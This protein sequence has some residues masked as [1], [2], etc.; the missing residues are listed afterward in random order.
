MSV[1][2]SS[3]KGPA[4]GNTT[5]G[6]TIGE[7]FR[8]DALI[9][10]GAMGVV[11]RAHHIGLHKD[12]ALKLLRRELSANAEMV[13]RF[14]REAAAASRLDHV[15]CVR[16]LDFG[17]TDDGRSYLVM[18][19]LDGQELAA[20]VGAP[21][22]HDRA[23]GILE[24]VLR[25]LGHAHAHGLVHRDVKPENIFL[26]EGSSGPVVKLLDFGLVKIQDAQGEGAA[27]LTRA[28]AIFGT[29]SYM[30]PEQCVGKN[31]DL[32]TDIYSA[33]VVM[34]EML[35]GDRPFVGDGPAEVLRGHVTD[36]PPPI[37]HA[38]PQ[39]LREL[40]VRMMQKKAEDRF[41]TAN[42]ALAAL[43]AAKRQLGS[44]P[45]GAPPRRGVAL[46]PPVPGLS[47][48]KPPGVSPPLS[49]PGSTVRAA[50]PVVP[51]SPGRAMPQPPPAEA[52]GPSASG[53]LPQI[54][55]PV[56]ATPDAPRAP[57]VATPAPP[58]PAAAPPSPAAS[59]PSPA[60]GGP[61]SAASSPSARAIVDDAVARVRA[62]LN[63]RPWLKPA[64]IGGVAL[65]A[66]LVVA[67]WPGDDERGA[68]ASDANAAD[69]EV[70]ADAR[71]DAKPDDDEAA[72]G[73]KA[74]DEIAID[75]ADG[76]AAGDEPGR[77][78]RALR[79][80]L[81]SIDALLETKNYDSARIMLGPLLEVYEDEPGLHWRMATVLVRL[82]PKTNG[83][84]ALQSYR[85][86][87]ALDAALLDDPK[88]A[89]ELWPLLDQPKHRVLATE[90]AVELLGEAAHERLA[91]WINVQASPLPHAVRHRVID[92]LTAAGKA[93]TINAPLQVALDLW[94]AQATDAPCDVFADALAAAEEAPDS[95]LW[96]SIVD[97]P[98][99]TA[100]EGAECPGVAGSRD[101]L[102]A[103]YAERYAGLARIVPAAYAKK[104]RRPK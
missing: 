17:S 55:A 14:D 75:P 40:V 92:H 9:G 74:D 36:A 33:G 45:A 59:S 99:P 63:Q 84:A 18:E 3:E 103:Q 28:G 35:T 29:P 97:A 91:R 8:I 21:L 82:N 42:A 23:I 51:V 34:Y 94:Q 43:E 26:A 7:R 96:G 1:P 24:Q 62:Q 104:R 39:P 70:A 64:L 68:A 90:I 49:P 102:A 10:E 65:L 2:P 47:R 87:L 41:P 16:V 57:N 89:N 37:S 61:S 12:V 98:T 22:P 78:D 11:Y 32:R 19:L 20:L 50:S 30:S 46:P 15:N 44:E 72:D 66:I 69:P 52:T 31:I 101:A 79:A 25:G 13:A 56:F 60:A 83:E 100:S 27:P 76:G 58:S 86:A 6:R 71:D 5:L 81:A 48:P 93:G 38:V 73:A 77:A 88:F 80:N 53:P 67:S 85:N 4:S 95:F 54:P